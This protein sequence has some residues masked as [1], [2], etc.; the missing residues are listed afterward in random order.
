MSPDMQAVLWNVKSCKPMEMILVVLRE[1][2]EGD[3]QT[4]RGD[5]WSTFRRCL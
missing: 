1:Q 3:D 5:S 4:G 2:S